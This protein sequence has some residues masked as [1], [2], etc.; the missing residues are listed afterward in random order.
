VSEE[1]E[2]LYPG[3]EISSRRRVSAERLER[4]KAGLTLYE[5]SAASGLGVTLLSLAERGIRRLDWR[6]E[7]ARRA[8]LARLI[9]A[10]R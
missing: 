5:L 1:G 4:L 6:Q 2:P 3:G 9:G 10:T 7:Q 8:A